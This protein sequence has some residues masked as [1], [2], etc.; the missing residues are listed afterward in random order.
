VFVPI[1]NVFAIQLYPV[2]ASRP[3]LVGGGDTFLAPP[4]RA[5]NGVNNVPK[6]RE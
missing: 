6:C 2:H 5:L 1:G 3:I 4:P